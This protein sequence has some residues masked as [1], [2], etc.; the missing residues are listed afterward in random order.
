[1]SSF[2]AFELVQIDTGVSLYSTHA[3]E[4]EIL[5]ANAC[6]KARGITSRFV[7]AGSFQV[8]SLHG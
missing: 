1:M 4:T 5:H 8:P 7:P 6:L 3:T 2:A